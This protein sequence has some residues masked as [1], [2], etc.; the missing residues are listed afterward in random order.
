MSRRKNKSIRRAILKVL[1]ARGW[2]TL[3]AIAR[4][5]GTTIRTTKRHLYVLLR[6]QRKVEVLYYYPKGRLYRRKNK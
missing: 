5:T 6:F 1:E 4:E 3:S 2:M